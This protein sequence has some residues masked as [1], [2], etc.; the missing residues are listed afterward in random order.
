M[1]PSDLKYEHELRHPESYFFDRKTMRFFGDTMRNYG[2]RKAA[3]KTDYDAEGNYTGR[4]TESVDVWE[5]FR[6]SPVKC[7][8]TSSAFF[9]CDDFRRVHPI[10]WEK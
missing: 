3:V 2:V 10:Q 1:T 5:L 7:G 4:P 9:A 6:R 8:N